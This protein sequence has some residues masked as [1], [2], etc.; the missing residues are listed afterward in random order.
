MTRARFTGGRSS[1]RWQL[2]AI[3]RDFND[4]TL[5]RAG[6]KDIAID[7]DDD[8]DGLLVGGGRFSE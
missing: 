1:R 2:H 3:E 8:A 4:G 7:V 5:G 6:V